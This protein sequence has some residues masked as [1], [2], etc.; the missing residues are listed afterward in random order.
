MIIP[1]SLST[2]IGEY[3]FSDCSGITNVMIGNGVTGIGEYAFDE[4]YR[5]R[6]VT[7]PDSVTSIGYYA[8]YGC[9]SLTSV[10]FKNSNGWWY[11]SSADATSGTAISSA[12]LA[13]TA[14]AATYLK[15]TYNNKYWKRS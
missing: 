12:D 1:D 7:I 9:N 4:C 3:A 15:S 13:K 11:A 10:E 6:S 14:T 2:S 5:L 8:F